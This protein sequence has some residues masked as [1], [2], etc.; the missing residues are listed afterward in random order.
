LIEGP[1]PGDADFLGRWLLAAAQADQRLQK[2]FERNPGL[3]QQISRIEVARI[4]SFS[5][6]ATK[7]VE[8]LMKN[9]TCF[10]LFLWIEWGEIFA[11]MADLGFFRR[12]G[13]RYQM[14]IPKG[15]SGSRIQAALVRLAAT[16]DEECFLHPEHLVTCL[17]TPDVQEWQ[18]R[19]ERQPW[20]QRIADR[21]ILL[22]D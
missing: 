21:N 8:L 6:A 20:K 17:S 7:F 12:T 4:V 2:Q 15:I 18:L 5:T 13:D 1:G 22:E 9:L 10:S 11:V 14:T 19:L 16:E 3:K